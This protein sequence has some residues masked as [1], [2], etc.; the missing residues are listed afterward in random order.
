[1]DQSPVDLVRKAVLSTCTGDLV[2]IDDRTPIRVG[3][4]P[5]NRGLTA[6]E[7]KKLTRDWVQKGGDIECTREGREGYRE[8]RDFYYWV[9][10]QGLAEFPK[11]LFVEME[12]TDDDQSDPVVSL[13]NAHPPAFP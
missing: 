9:V 12:L 11:G 4:D 6:D 13:L 10:I 7:I 2:W 8:K 5:R 1:M 3:N